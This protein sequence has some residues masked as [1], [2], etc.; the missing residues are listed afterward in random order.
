[1]QKG[2]ISFQASKKGIANENPCFE[3]LEDL[4]EKPFELIKEWNGK[5]GMESNGSLKSGAPKTSHGA[6]GK[7]KWQ[8]STFNFLVAN[9]VFQLFIMNI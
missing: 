9:K 3:I 1:M 4:I 6:C 7:H 5:N 2:R 8:A